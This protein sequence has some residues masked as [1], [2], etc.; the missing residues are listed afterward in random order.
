[1]LQSAAFRISAI[2]TPALAAVDTEA[3]R[4]EWALKMLVSIPYFAMMVFNQLA[5]VEEATALCGL[6]VAIS[7]FVT[8]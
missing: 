5:I 6:I 7:N 2:V 4:T 3:L 8:L 1:M